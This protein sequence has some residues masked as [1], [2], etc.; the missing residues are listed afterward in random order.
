MAVNFRK[1]FLKSVKG[2][3]ILAFIFAFFALSLAW[4]ISKFAFGKMLSVV[5]EISQ[6]NARLRI[7]N[8]L[9]HKIAQLDQL[10]R[11]EAFDDERNENFLAE[12]KK[13]R[14]SLDTLRG[15]YS[16]DQ[17]QLAKIKS[18]KNLL[19]DRDKQFL[20]YLNVRENLV[21]TKSF[22]EDV[23]KLSELVN[24]QSKQA[25]SAVTTQTTTSTTTVAPDDE[26]K[27]RS[28][29]SKIFGKKKADAYKIINQELKIRRDTI[30]P[31]VEDSL[32]NSMERTLKGIAQAQ[33]IKGRKFLQQESE[34]AVASNTLTRQMLKI[35]R[36]VES[37]AV[38]QMDLNGQEAKYVVNSSIRQ[39]TA[40]LIIFFILTLILLYLILSDIAK[41]NRYRRALEI[42]K[43]EAEYHGKAKQRFLSNMSH[44]IRTPLQAILGYS[45]LVMQQDSPQ[46]K[47]INAIYQSS[48]HLLQIVNEILDY[49]R[50]ISG[51][52]TFSNR[53]F[54]MQD[55]VDEVVSVIQSLAEKKFLQVTTVI[56]AP[57]I[58]F[59]KGDAFRLKQVL[60]NIIGNAVKFT[61]KGGIKLS[62]VG[63]RQNEHVHFIFV[64]EDT[65]IGFAESQVGN[66]FNEFE[67][68][69]GPENY[70]ANQTGTGLGLSIVKSLVDSQ[71]GRIHVKSKPGFGTTFSVFLKYEYAEE[72]FDD[73]LLL[74]TKVSTKQTVWVI[75]DDKLILDLCGLIFER[76]NISFRCFS[77]VA[78]IINEEPVGSLAFILI[79]MRLPE[80]SGLELCKI[81]KTRLP[82]HIL[83]YA[84]TAQV[85]PDEQALV[86]EE[87]FEGLIMKPFREVDLLSIF[88][89]IE[90][91][92]LKPEVNLSYIEQMTF[93]DQELLKKILTV[94]KS[95]SISD[96]ERL[97]KVLI[98]KNHAESRLIIHRLAGRMAQIGAKTLADSFRLLEIDVAEQGLTASIEQEALNQLRELEQVLVV[99]EE[100]KFAQIS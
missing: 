52:F 25:D 57:G 55:A 90:V 72:E 89:C 21:N 15:L 32:V 41:S 54:R 87:G 69:D 5:E 65:G 98:E 94:C 88:D 23:K 64:I 95:D 43:D 76:N 51:E 34:L 17:G 1:I 96:L 68:I 24:R 82:S 79:D 13:I 50:I 37:Q 63:K 67:Q 40:I 28:F 74:N 99:L 18:L 97:K 71:G 70:A 66:I 47:D 56:D 78:E 11:V 100:M 30:N 14:L 9:T 27:S 92:E 59:V 2:K 73:S 6:P 53:V 31:K 48:V 62:V 16:T 83:F 8:D 60:Y 22:S 93:G 42:A 12:S 36:E 35:L 61:F 26:T 91:D 10:Q 81:L 46:K 3:V 39:I 29:L 20:A 85:L 4:Y 45:E 38:L 7:V 58:D 49:N 86:L 19:K 75:D 33:R 84:I 77:E 44:E 80:M